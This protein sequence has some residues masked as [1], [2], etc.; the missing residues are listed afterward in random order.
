MT[1]TTG[2]AFMAH[3]AHADKM[4]CA[5]PFSIVESSFCLKMIT[6]LKMG[7]LCYLPKDDD[8]C[9]T[10]LLTVFNDMVREINEM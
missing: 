5:F 10:Y 7:Y 2:C 8:F 3:P 9:R 6:T 4:G 1:Y